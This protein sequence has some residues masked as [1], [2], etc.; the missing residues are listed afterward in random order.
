MKNTTW[1]LSFF[2]LMSF[3]ACTTQ[4]TFQNSGALNTISIELADD[5]VSYERL[6]SEFERETFGGFL[7]GASSQNVV[8][9]NIITNNN[10][11]KQATKLGVFG[12]NLASVI[13]LSFTTVGLYLGIEPELQKRNDE[14]ERNFNVVA[15]V[16]AAGFG[17][18]VNESIWRP[19]NRH[20]ITAEAVRNTMQQNPDADFYSFPHSELELRP[21][22][23][24]T[25]W[26]GNYRIIAGNVSKNVF[27]ASIASEGTGIDTERVETAASPQE[28]TNISTTGTEKSMDLPS[29]RGKIIKVGTKGVYAY[30]KNTSQAFRVIEIINFKGG[31]DFRIAVMLQGAQGP[32][33]T[34]FKASNK[35]LI[36]D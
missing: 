18:I 29:V 10:G 6:N 23:F 30:S 14:V 27:G 28:V 20:R 13:S 16:L 15:A 34:T 1:L 33:E 36:F 21:E 8:E 32:F 7:I 25:K 35:K 24:G 3:S 17:F 31:D 22:L 12:A 26:R 5:N 9:A 2:V 11:E 4:K 19:F